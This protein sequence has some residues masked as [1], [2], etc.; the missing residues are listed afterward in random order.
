MNTTQTYKK[1]YSQLNESRNTI[2]I[3]SMSYRFSKV[4]ENKYLKLMSLQQKTL[5]F[6]SIIRQLESNPLVFYYHLYFR[7]I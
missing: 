6:S 7:K 2:H 1:N 5:Q 3:S 4:D